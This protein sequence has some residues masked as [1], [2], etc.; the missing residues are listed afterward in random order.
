MRRAVRTFSFQPRP[1]AVA[2]WTL[3]ALAVIGAGAAVAN[4]TGPVG[5]RGQASFDRP[6]SSVLQVTNAQGTVIQWQ[7]FPS[8]AAT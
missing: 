7:G 3:G 8:A 4:P 6:S 1:S 5:T 2:L